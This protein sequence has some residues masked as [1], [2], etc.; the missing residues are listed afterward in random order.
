MSNVQNENTSLAPVKLTS[1][2][3]ITGTSSVA[4]MLESFDLIDIND[5]RDTYA[6]DTTIKE[7]QQYLTICIQRN[8]NP[9]AGQVHFI[10][11][12]INETRKATIQISIDGLR[13]IAKNTGDYMGS[14]APVWGPMVAADPKIYADA[15]DFYFPEWCSVTTYTYSHGMRVPH[16]FVCY[17]E[18]YVATKAEWIEKRLTGKRII[19]DMWSKFKRRMI[20]KCA[21]AGSLR[22]GNPE[23]SGLYTHDEM[24]QA[25]QPNF[26]SQGLAET[27]NSFNTP[28]V[29]DA[30][31]HITEVIDE[32]L[33][34]N[35]EKYLTSLAFPVSC[36]ALSEYISSHPITKNIQW[37]TLNNEIMAHNQP[38]LDLIKKQIAIELGS[39]F[40]MKQ[41]KDFSNTYEVDLTTGTTQ[42]KINMYLENGTRLV[43]HIKGPLPV[44][45]SVE[46]VA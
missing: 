38:L 21:E 28:I 10:V 31:V 14:D 45:E 27:S 2:P 12:G 41:Y 23:C 46:S 18:E 8:L 40:T 42:E 16:C 26:S 30:D 44:E 3:R 17:W 5:L 20:A 11:R 37:I 33:R 4:K 19:T 22:M 24:M 32:H 7:F 9:F 1:K 6:K 13:A 34:E 36:Q 43:N 15:K 25:D 35:I 39:P 29:V